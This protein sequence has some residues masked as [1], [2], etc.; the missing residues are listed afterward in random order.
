MV[1]PYANVC[2]T[3]RKYTSHAHIAGSGWD[4]L[5]ALQVKAEWEAALGLDVSGPEENVL[6]A[7][8]GE[9]RAR[10]QDSRGKIGVWVDTVSP[11]R[12]IHY[13]QCGRGRTRTTRTTSPPEGSGKR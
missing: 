11:R 1:R 13:K 2:S 6:E 8:S 3:S 5:S 4:Y 7:G 10:V 12:V 9:S